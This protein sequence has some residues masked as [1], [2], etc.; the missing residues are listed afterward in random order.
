MPASR[1]RLAAAIAV[2]GL[3]A[4]VACAAS[5]PAVEGLGTKVRLPIFHGAM[6]WVNL[7]AFALLGVFAVGSLVT[8]RRDVHFFEEGLRYVAIPLWVVGS[9]LG[10]MAALNTWDFTGSRSGR[11]EVVAADPRLMAQ[12]WIM[13]AGLVVLVVCLMLD[14]DR[15]LASVLDIA[16][17]G[18][19][20]FIL[21]RAILGPGR[22]LHPDSPVLN[23]DE[24]LIKALFFGVVAS[25]GIATLAGA[26]LIAQW[27]ERRVLA[28]AEGQRAAIEAG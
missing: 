11:F 3:V 15:K 24:I 16:F 9:V 28:S 22:A 27:R 4:A 26:Y 14:D 7:A 10:L 8:G 12:F 13:L 17:V 21:L 23:S 1:S 19:A 5:F 6:T 18:F 25:L 2:L 20:W